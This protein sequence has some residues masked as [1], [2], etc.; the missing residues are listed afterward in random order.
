[1]EVG[2][3]W[4]LAASCAAERFLIRQIN[5]KEFGRRVAFRNPSWLKC[6]LSAGRKLTFLKANLA[7][8]V[9]GVGREERRGERENRRGG[10]GT[11]GWGALGGW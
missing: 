7:G 10:R 8:A 4:T 5:F 2:Y 1:M 11:W 6:A 3:I 9:K